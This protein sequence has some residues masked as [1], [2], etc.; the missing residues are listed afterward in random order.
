MTDAEIE[1]EKAIRPKQRA[2]LARNLGVIE[3]L[4]R[5]CGRQAQKTHK[6]GPIAHHRFAPHFLFEVHRRVR[7]QKITSVLFLCSNDARQLTP[8]Q[9]L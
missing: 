9:A 6:S 4:P 3:D 7:G 5:L 8:S 1:E 2:R